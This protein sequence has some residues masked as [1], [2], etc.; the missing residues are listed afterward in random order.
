VVGFGPKVV[1]GG[2]RGALTDRRAKRESKGSLDAFCGSCVRLR[3]FTE[4]STRKW[5]LIGS[6]F[7]TCRTASRAYITGKITVAYMFHAIRGKT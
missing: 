2:D 1:L 7:F 4:W 5:V 3:L 6:H